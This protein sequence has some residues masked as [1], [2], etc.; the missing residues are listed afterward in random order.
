MAS[1]NHRQAEINSDRANDLA[2]EV[3]TFYTYRQPPLPT[4]AELAQEM[5]EEAVDLA[6]DPASHLRTSRICGELASM[7]HEWVVHSGSPS[8][9]LHP[10]SEVQDHYGRKI[11]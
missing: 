4:D 8:S 11:D 5:F 7:L 10:L 6:S 2:V 3:Y 1:P 9:H